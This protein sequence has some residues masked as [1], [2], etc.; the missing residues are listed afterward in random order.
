MLR[1]DRGIAKNAIVTIEPFEQRLR[2]IEANLRRQQFGKVIHIDPALRVVSRLCFK[3]G[4]YCIAMAVP[5]R[6]VKG[7]SRFS[8]PPEPLKQPSARAFQRSPKA[9]HGLAFHTRQAPR[10]SR[11]GP[12]VVA[13]APRDVQRWCLGTRATA[14]P[15]PWVNRRDRAAG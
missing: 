4:R 13:P 12:P 14:Q 9:A 1:R 15:Y 2:D 5:G 7:P 11:S 6:R 3:T 8:A 10:A